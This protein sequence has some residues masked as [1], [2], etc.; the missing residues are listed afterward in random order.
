MEIGSDALSPAPVATPS[1]RRARL[2]ELYLP[3]T[4]LIL[5]PVFGVAA[6]PAYAPLLFTVAVAQ[7]VHR[8]I[9]ER[10]VMRLDT[11]W[12]VLAALFALLCWASAAWSIVPARSLRGAMQV[13]LVLLGAMIVLAQARLPDDATGKLMR[14]MALAFLVGGAMVAVDRLANYPI[15][16]LVTDGALNAPTKYNRGIAYAVLIA[17]PV[18]ASLWRSRAVLY[19]GALLLG[20]AL[21]VGFGLSLTAKLAAL[22]ALLIFAAAVI[23]PRLAALALAAGTAAFALFCPLLLH[24]LA[25]HRGALA[26]Y[27]KQSGQ[28]RLEIWDYMTARVFERPFHGWGFW[29]ANAVPITPRELSSYRWV[30]LQGIYPHDQWLQLWVETG[31][32]GAVLGLAFVVLVLQRVRRLPQDLRPFA[33]AAFAAAAAVSLADFDVATDSWWAALAICAFLFAQ[34]AALPA[35]RRG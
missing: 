9:A 22:A 26:P 16:S 5:L 13:T 30:S 19:L 11:S 35:A 6:G 34:A 12:L 7:F 21:M 15:E 31:L 10:R 17:C 14:M 2:F 29:S 4:A 27:L 23:A 18:A 20:S 3:M 28:A 33:Y 25:S 24:L 8:A 32:F 1:S